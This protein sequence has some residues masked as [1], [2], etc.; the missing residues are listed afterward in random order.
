MSISS[1]ISRI[2]GNVSAALTAIGNK[3]VTVPAGSNSD[4]LATLIGS[5]QTGGGGGMTAT[6][7]I[8]GNGANVLQIPC[9]FEP[10]L[11][12]IHGDLSEDVATRGIVFLTIIKDMD[13]YY[14]LD[15]STSAS[16]T[17]AGAIQNITGYN[18]SDT[19]DIHATYSN[20]T[21]SVDTVVNSGSFRWT[22][23]ITYEYELIKFG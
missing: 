17:N 2:S 13:I 9:D 14:G 20:N 11:I 16:I 7:T 8:V 23:G 22:S 4:D 21:L 3:G 10:D 6:G 5:I 12:R 18:E 1:E 19:S 15:S